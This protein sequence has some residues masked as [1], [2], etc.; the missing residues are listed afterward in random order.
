MIF[1]PNVGERLQW[2]DEVNSILSKK[3]LG[4]RVEGNVVM[5]DFDIVM[6]HFSSNR[7]LLNTIPETKQILFHYMRGLDK[8]SISVKILMQQLQTL[9]ELSKIK[10]GNTYYFFRVEDR[11]I[12]REEDIRKLEEGYQNLVESFRAVARKYLYTLLAGVEELQ[13]KIAEQQLQSAMFGQ[14][15]QMQTYPQY[16]QQAQTGIQQYPQY[17]AQPGDQNQLNNRRFQQ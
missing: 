16:P 14:P 17:P 10:I 7:A 11:T 2:V 9:R 15:T 3:D 6:G 13:Q 4:Y 12:L 8:I 5:T 1:L